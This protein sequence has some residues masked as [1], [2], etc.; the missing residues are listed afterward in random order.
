MFF[1]KLLL[2]FFVK[3]FRFLV[4]LVLLCGCLGGEGEI[5]PT[6]GDT[7]LTTSA[8]YQVPSTT[9][10]VDVSDSPRLVF[11][12]YINAIKENDVSTL[13]ALYTRKQDTSQIRGLLETTSSEGLSNAFFNLAPGEVQPVIE[14]SGPVHTSYETYGRLYS[15]DFKLGGKTYGAYFVFEDVGWRIPVSRESYPYSGPSVG[16]VPLI[17]QGPSGPCSNDDYSTEESTGTP[18]GLITLTPESRRKLYSKVKLFGNRAL[19]G[20]SDLTCLEYL[21]F[22]GWPISDVSHL[23][24]LHKLEHLYL[25]KTELV[26]LSPL[27]SLTGLEELKLQQTDI[28]DVSPLSSL[29]NMKT[30][31]LEYTQ[32]SDISALENMR[33]LEYLSA[34]KTNVEDL[35][36]LQQHYALKELFLGFTP[37]T[38]VSALNNLQSLERLLLHNTRV[39]DVRPLG[40]LRSLREL[41]LGGTPLTDATGLENLGSLKT[42]HLYMSN[43]TRQEC[44]RL[45]KALVNAKV[46]CP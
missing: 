1:F 12:R 42:L 4:L 29:S 23:S 9:L 24:G 3:E 28:E 7:V 10:R 34:F 40:N 14:R 38:D 39:T 41:T 11:E 32:V 37:V 25:D 43:V 18:V 30:L 5:E 35:T 15:I 2:Y 21:N 31:R 8:G 20:I 16:L 19:E 27:S 44:D 17:P 33:D 22:E 13:L 36:P 26:D 46:D 6:T 45:K